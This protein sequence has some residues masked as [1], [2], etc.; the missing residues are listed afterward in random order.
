VPGLLA[1]NAPGRLWLA[2]E[3]GADLATIKSLYRSAGAEK[4][5]TVSG[6]TERADA[7]VKWLLA[8]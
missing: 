7:A 5:L 8:K 2:G 4:N 3:A 1:L 6:K